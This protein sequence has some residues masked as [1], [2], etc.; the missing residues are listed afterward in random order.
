MKKRKSRTDIIFES[1]H[2]GD[3]DLAPDAQNKRLKFDNLDLDSIRPKGSRVE[4]ASVKLKTELYDRIKEIAQHQGINQPG[5]FISKILEA[6][7]M[8]TESNTS[9]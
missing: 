9:K 8:Q 1:L 6:Y 7:L 2:K 4:Y 5:K 3:T